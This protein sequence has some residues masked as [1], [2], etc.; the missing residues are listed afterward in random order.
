MFLPFPFFAFVFP[1]GLFFL[2]I[3]CFCFSPVRK[4]LPMVYWFPPSYVAVSSS[5]PL[6]SAASSHGVLVYWSPAS[7]LVRFGG[8]LRFGILRCVLR[9][10]RFGRGRGFVAVVGRDPTF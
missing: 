5:I 9:V 8:V 4:P 10:S 3:P 1:R 6:R 7:R 2:L